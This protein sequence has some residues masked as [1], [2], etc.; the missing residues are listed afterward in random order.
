MDV[1]R[2]ISYVFQDPSWIKKIL[3]GGVLSI[4]PI[5]GTL[6]VLGYWTRIARNVSNG[7][8]VPLPE[9]DDFGGDFMRGLKAFVAV[10]IWALPFIILFSCGWIPFAALGNSSNGAA[11]A[12]AG[13]FGV[14]LFGLGTLCGIAIGF[15]SPVIVGRVILRDSVS[16]AFEFSAVINDARENVVPLLIIVGMS[17]ALGFVASFGMILCFIGVFFTYFLAYVML[18]HL[19]GQLWRRLGSFSPVSTG[20]IVPGPM[21]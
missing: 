16:A 3:I 10:F 21:S 15:I 8:E 18:S 13:I 6:V 17:Y 12:L 7:M 2:S 4:I 5:F 14:G 9:W 20:T 19:Y 11:S 1:G